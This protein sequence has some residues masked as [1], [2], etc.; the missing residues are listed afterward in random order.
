MAVPL[1]QHTFVYKSLQSTLSIP[2]SQA[3]LTTFDLN[4]HNEQEIRNNYTVSIAQ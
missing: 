4:L 3:T 2:D 1:L